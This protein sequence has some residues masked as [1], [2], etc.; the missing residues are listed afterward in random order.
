M[1]NVM[2]ACQRAVRQMEY[3]LFTNGGAERLLSTL[4]Y[5]HDRP[6][7]REVGVLKGFSNKSVLTDYYT[8]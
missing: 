7:I 1:S 5:F 3:L 8:K 6:L 2:D 4:R